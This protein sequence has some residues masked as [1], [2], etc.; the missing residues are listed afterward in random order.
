MGFG[1][2]YRFSASK[3]VSLYRNYAVI[4]QVVS[5]PPPPPHNY[6]GIAERLV[7]QQDL[8]DSQVSRHPYGY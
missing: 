5:L 2:D 1:S 4:S 6:T 8:L 7:C 3:I